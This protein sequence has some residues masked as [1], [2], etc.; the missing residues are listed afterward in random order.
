MRVPIN[1]NKRKMIEFFRKLLDFFLIP[2]FVN[3]ILI[4]N[5][6]RI[7]EVLEPLRVYSGTCQ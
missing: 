3:I 7:L 6:L 2:T 1:P 4:N 5:Y